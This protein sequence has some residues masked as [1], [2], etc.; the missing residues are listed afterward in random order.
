MFHSVIWKPQE[1]NISPTPVIFT[2]PAPAPIAPSCVQASSGQTWSSRIPAYDYPTPAPN[3]DHD[4][5]VAICDVEVPI[6]LQGTDKMEVERAAA[7]TQAMSCG[8][9]KRVSDVN[10]TIRVLR[11]LANP[12]KPH[13]ED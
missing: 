11:S 8:V 9:G 2:P 12:W 5:E 7:L 6:L 1:I 4:K 10:S 13:S 3:P